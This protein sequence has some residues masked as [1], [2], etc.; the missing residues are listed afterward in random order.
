MMSLFRWHTLTRTH[1][2]THSHIHTHVDL[3]LSP[4]PPSQSVGIECTPNVLASPRY[5]ATSSCFEPRSYSLPATRNSVR[6]SP[7]GDNPSRRN[8]THSRKSN[9]WVW[10]VHHVMLLKIALYAYYGIICV[11]VGMWLLCTQV[12]MIK[13]AISLISRKLLP[14]FDFFSPLLNHLLGMCGFISHSPNNY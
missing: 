11:H 13:V 2:H 5:S 4:L 9:R 7:H 12:I 14:Y 6:C 8:S 1:T 10:F 3:S